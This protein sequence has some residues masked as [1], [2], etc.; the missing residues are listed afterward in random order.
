MGKARQRVMASL[1]DSVVVLSWAT[2][3][4]WMVS[5]DERGGGV[6]SGTCHLTSCVSL[7]GVLC[8]ASKYSVTPHPSAVPSCRWVS[9]KVLTL[10]GRQN[11]M[12]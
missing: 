11:E 1:R 7:V 4:G 3:L 2:Q 8:C 10:L 6:P 12:Q 5:E 9:S